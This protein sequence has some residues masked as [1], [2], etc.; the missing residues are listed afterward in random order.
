VADICLSLL[1]I[2]DAALLLGKVRREAAGDAWQENGAPRVAGLSAHPQRLSHVEE[3]QKW[4]GLAQPRLAWIEGG[5]AGSAGSQ[6][7]ACG[8]CEEGGVGEVPRGTDHGLLRVGGAENP[9]AL[10][11][12]I[13]Q[14][15][16]GIKLETYH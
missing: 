1:A 12:F 7:L 4:V 15:A 10:L 9:E 14:E 13:E 8:R 11:R 6:E 2:E 5:D 3:A 16:N